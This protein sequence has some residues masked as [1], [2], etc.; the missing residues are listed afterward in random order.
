MASR[1][2]SAFGFPSSSDTWSNSCSCDRVLKGAFWGRAGIA[3]PGW[4]KHS[5]LD[6]PWA[7]EV[8]RR[9]VAQWC[10]TIDFVDRIVGKND[11]QIMLWR[12]HEHQNTSRPST[13]FSSAGN[14]MILARRP[15]ADA[16]T[17][18]TSPFCK[19][20]RKRLAVGAGI[21]ADS[22]KFELLKTGRSKIQSRARIAY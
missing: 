11:R 4:Q 19:T 8:H 7:S 10:H 16:N 1:T 2:I 9:F 14:A 6:D 5:C 3:W 12:I 15:L 21:I 17:C 13:M 18:N 20:L 22:T